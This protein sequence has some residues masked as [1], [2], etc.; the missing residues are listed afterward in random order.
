MHGVPSL[1]PGVGALSLPCIRIGWG[2]GQGFAVILPPVWVSRA[3]EEK[4]S[5][6]HGLGSFQSA[7]VC[8]GQRRALAFVP[9]A[10]P[11]AI[12]CLSFLAPAPLT[13]QPRMTSAILNS[14]VDL[15]LLLFSQQ[16]GQRLHSAG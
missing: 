7:Q 9:L 4:F 5:S 3:L 14:P 6:R 12:I 10:A 1:F 13:P 15:S 8:L 2:L 16:R 11:P